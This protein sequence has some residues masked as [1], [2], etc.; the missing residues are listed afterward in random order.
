MN[1]KVIKCGTVQFTSSGKLTLQLPEHMTKSVVNNES[2]YWLRARIIA[3]NYGE[4]EI[5][6]IE[7]DGEKITRYEH[8]RATFAPPI[9]RTLKLTYEY[10]NSDLQVMCRTQNN[11]EFSDHSVNKDGRWSRLRRS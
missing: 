10:S 7:I 3:G 8:K 1:S 4:E 6:D 5:Y 2:G 9:V 11:F